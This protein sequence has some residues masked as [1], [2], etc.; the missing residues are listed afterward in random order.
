MYR[1]V[2][3]AVLTTF[4][5]ASLATAQPGATSPTP[6]RKHEPGRMRQQLFERLDLSDQQKVQMR[7]LRVENQKDMTELHAKIQIARLDLKE[8]FAADKLDRGAIE[9]KI[10]AI[11][12]LQHA[13]KIKMLDHLFAANALLSPEQQKIWKEHMGMMGAGPRGPMRRG[14]RGGIMFGE[15]MPGSDEPFN[16]DGPELPEEDIH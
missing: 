3:L 6:M 9:K 8:L 5:A 10:S 2:A 4:F 11:S 12:D 1:T 13:A 15:G 14:G 16:E 7:K